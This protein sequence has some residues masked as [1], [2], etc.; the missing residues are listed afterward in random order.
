MKISESKKGKSSGE[1]NGHYGK[2]TSDYAKNRTS[3]S[4][5]KTY[6]LTNINGEKIIVEN[7][8]KFCKDNQIP[9]GC[10]R[11]LRSGHS[12]KYKE[13]IK[14]ETKSQM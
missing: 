8:P 13:W 12:K 14:I 4:N 2:K 9:L 5:R 6:E 1:N 11:N 10:I 7:L 3:E